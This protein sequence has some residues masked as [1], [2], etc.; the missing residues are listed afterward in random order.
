MDSWPTV[1]LSSQNILGR[2]SRQSLPSSKPG[3]RRTQQR[4]DYV[5]IRLPFLLKDM[6]T[7]TRA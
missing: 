5:N 7:I 6:N 4:I 1:S 2:L 3:S